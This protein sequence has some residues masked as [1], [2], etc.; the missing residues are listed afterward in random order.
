[1]SLFFCYAFVGRHKRHIIILFSV[2]IDCVLYVVAF[3]VGFADSSGLFFVTN[4]FNRWLI[5]FYITTHVLSHLALC[6][7]SVR[8]DKPSSFTMLL[9]G[10]AS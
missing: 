6:V 3:N 4:T 5:V 10:C 2:C 9:V 1:M 7:C 8:L